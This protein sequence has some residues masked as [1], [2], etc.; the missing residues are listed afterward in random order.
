M[1]ILSLIGALSILLVPLSSAG[2]A[3]KFKIPV[4]A[5]SRALGYAPLWVADKKGFFERE[6]LRVEVTAMHGTSPCLRALVAESI[7][8]ALA[9]NDGVV[10]LVEKGIE[11]LAIIAGGSKSTHMII[12][13]KHI[14]NYGDLRGTTIGVSTLTSGTAFLLRRVLKA[15]GLEYP[16]DYSLVNVGGGGP[17][18]IAIASGNV[19]AGIVSVPLNFRARQ[20]GLSM[21]GKVTDVFPNYLLSS[22]SVRRRWAQEHR[23]EVVKFLKALLKAHKWLEEN[24]HDGAA[25]LADELRLKPVLARQGLDYYLDHR[26][27]EPDLGVNL[28]GLKGVLEVYR[29]Q[30]DTPG[31][32]PNPEKYLEMSYLKTALQEL[33]EK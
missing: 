7:H 6:G 15:N 4:A 3:E 13:K 12:G 11:D 2:V 8:A 28:K 29:K 14:K 23:A 16:K 1:N 25:F 31:P 21:I 33:R 26:A 24:R 10:A 30:T 5:S 17:A 27:W 9:G 32:L 19:A 22:F 18:L 20:L